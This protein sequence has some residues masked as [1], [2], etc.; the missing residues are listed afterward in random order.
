MRGKNRHGFSQCLWI[1]KF[2]RYYFRL[3]RMQF[4]LKN[5]RT[6]FFKIQVKKTIKIKHGT[7]TLFM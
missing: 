4:N 7:L 5:K 1:I 3:I 2:E 6:P